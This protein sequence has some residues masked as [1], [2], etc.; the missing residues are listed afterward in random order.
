MQYSKDLI[1]VQ[2][3]QG[4]IRALLTSEIQFQE[5]SEYFGQRVTLDGIANFKP[6]GNV[7]TIEIRKVRLANGT[8]DWFTK[9]PTPIKEQLDFKEL[10]TKQKYKG[11]NLNNVIGEWPGDESIEELL[12]MLEK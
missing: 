6:S 8:D 11:T 10:R 12:E 4:A 5:V 2:T 1:Q 9:K 7:S 3:E